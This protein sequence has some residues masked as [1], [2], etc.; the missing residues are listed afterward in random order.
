VA[1]TYYKRSDH[2]LLKAGDEWPAS[3]RQT[4]G[5]AGVAGIPPWNTARYL[6]FRHLLGAIA[7]DSRVTIDQELAT[8]SRLMEKIGATDPQQIETA[9]TRV[10]QLVEQ[11]VPQV[12][13]VK[14]DGPL[15]STL[16]RSISSD[17]DTIAGAGL[18]AAEQA[19]MAIEA[20]FMAYRKQVKTA[21][22]KAIQ[23]TIQRLFEA[24]EKP[25]QYDPQQFSAHLQMLHGLFM[26]Q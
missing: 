8:L 14:L 19:A 24:L 9:A 5:Y 23:D 25:E 10:A 22:D 13:S 17:R 16:L 4:R 12:T 6:I 26:K 11:L 7:P 3:W 18:R 2:G 20:L 1:S 21:N 15:V